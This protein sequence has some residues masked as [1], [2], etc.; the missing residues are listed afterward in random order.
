[1]LEAVIIGSGRSTPGRVSMRRRILRLR[2]FN[3]RRT[4]AFTRKTSW[5]GTIGRVKS[6]DCSPKPGG[7]RASAPQSAWG[8]AWLRTRSPGWE[9][10]RDE[11]HQKGR[12]ETGQAS[13]PAGTPAAQPGL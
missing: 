10:S 8:D 1:M 2:R 7:F 4:L 5:V 13:H 9:V 6:L 12:G 11:D 3:W